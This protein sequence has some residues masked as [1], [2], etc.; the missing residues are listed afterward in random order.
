LS[1]QI[2]IQRRQKRIPI[3][4]KTNHSTEINKPNNKAIE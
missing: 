4:G 1:E 3:I 2:R